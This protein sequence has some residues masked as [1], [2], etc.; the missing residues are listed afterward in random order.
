MI[1]RNWIQVMTFI[2]CIFAIKD[3]ISYKSSFKYYL[4]LISDIL[5]NKKHQKR[6]SIFLILP[7]LGSDIY[8]NWNFMRWNKSINSDKKFRIELTKI[9]NNNLADYCMKISMIIRNKERYVFEIFIY[10]EKHLSNERFNNLLKKSQKLVGCTGD[11]SFSET[12]SQYKIPIY[13]AL[14]HKGE[15]EK[16]FHQYIKQSGY[17]NKN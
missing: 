15:F 14:G 8:E 11:Q 9:E 7:G 13:Q 16:S 5:F 3:P 6:K 12:I 2:F 4:H 1:T 10:K 17:S